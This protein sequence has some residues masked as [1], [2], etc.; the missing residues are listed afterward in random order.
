M[1][2]SV[3]RMERSSH[4]S[5]HRRA[6]SEVSR[7]NPWTSETLLIRALPES[8]DERP[9]VA[10]RYS[11]RPVRGT[12]RRMAMVIHPA[13]RPA[14][15]RARTRQI[16]IRSVRRAARD[17]GLAFDESGAVEGRLKQTE[18]L[19]LQFAGPGRNLPAGHGV[20]AV[21]KPP[22]ENSHAG[23]C[24][25]GHPGRDHSRRWRLL[26]RAPSLTGRPEVRRR[27]GPH[28]DFGEGNGRSK[29]S[30]VH[31]HRLRCDYRGRAGHCDGRRRKRGP[32]RRRAPR[33]EGQCS[34]DWDINTR[35]A[36]SRR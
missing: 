11:V 26:D 17:R 13:E 29:E 33:R 8:G 6:F 9:R 35:I 28:R 27:A 19:R 3:A 34:V 36:N 12:A 5:P 1:R 14:P 24:S 20:L 30:S 23:H 32:Q 16:S 2:A 7:R 4:R 21:T 25:L 10:S 22:E 18:N 31:R 15:V